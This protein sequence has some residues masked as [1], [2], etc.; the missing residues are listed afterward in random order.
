MA[1]CD[2]RRANAGLLSASR[3]I[4]ELFLVA[5]T[6][7]HLL[8]L[9][10]VAWHFVT[11]GGSW[12]LVA[13]QE[14]EPLAIDLHRRDKADKLPHRILPALPKLL[15]AQLR[16]LARSV[17]IQ[18]QLDAAFDLSKFHDASDPPPGDQ[19]IDLAVPDRAANFLAERHHV[20]SVV[21]ATPRLLNFD[22]AVRD[23]TV[24]KRLLSLLETLVSQSERP[25]Q[26]LYGN[27]L[28][29]VV[30]LLD[31]SSEQKVAPDGS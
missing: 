28:A 26:L 7:E 3:S 2:L 16:G 17:V 25:H 18:D 8:F 14:D 12:L 4:S 10:L 19:G 30:C 23:V 5:E 24:E 15:E 31:Q 22:G 13:L 6:S 20:V 21:V 9:C 11:F 27:L 1:G 29:Q